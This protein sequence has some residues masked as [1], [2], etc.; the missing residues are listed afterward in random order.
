MD[1]GLSWARDNWLKASSEVS[2][3]HLVPNP[4]LKLEMKES[5]NF[6]VCQVCGEELREE[7]LIVKCG[8][9]QTPHHRDCWDYNG[10]CAVFGC[11]NDATSPKPISQFHADDQ[12]LNIQPK[13]V[14]YCVRCSGII[15]IKES[16]IRC[17]KCDEPHHYGCWHNSCRSCECIEY[18]IVSK[19]TPADI[20]KDIGL[21][22]V[23]PTKTG[24]DAPKL[25]LTLWHLFWA[26]LIWHYFL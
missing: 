23:N 17:G 13:I 14:A 9:C 25:F 7:S 12:Y 8:Q 18:I 11:G 19:L 21:I 3:Q 15:P 24:E 22:A 6:P 26:W 16:F 4:D 20:A 1:L 2:D 5:K 10:K